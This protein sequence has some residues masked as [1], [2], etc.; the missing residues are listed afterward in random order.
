MTVIVNQSLYPLEVVQRAFWHGRLYHCMSI[1]ACFSFSECGQLGALRKAPE[2]EQNEVWRGRPMRSSL[3][4]PGDLIPFKPNTD[5]LVV[6]AAVA[7]NERPTRRWEAA[8]RFPGGEKRLRLCGPRA[9][10][11][12]L[13]SGWTLSEPEPAARVQLIHENAYGGVVDDTLEHFDE[14][15]YF[16]SNPFGCGFIGNT[17]PD[18]QQEHRA[19]QIEA[20]D[21]A[22]VRFGTHVAVG[23]LGHE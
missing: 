14:G 20:W 3:L 5:V 6:G 12:S 2:V 9:W 8:L 7:P 13:L 4:H 1:K 17:R 23:G 21:G 11:H 10:R 18:T 22:I 19:A 16:P 15:A